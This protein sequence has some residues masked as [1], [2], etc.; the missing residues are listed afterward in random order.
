M[1]AMMQYQTR[2]R[3]EDA[4]R[5]LINVTD[6]FKARYMIDNK[7]EVKGDILP[8][9]IDAQM[10]IAF[11]LQKLD[12]QRQEHTTELAQSKQ[13]IDERVKDLTMQALKDLQS[14]M[15]DQFYSLLDEF[16]RIKKDNNQ[17][18]LE[19]RRL[20]AMNKDHELRLVEV[21]TWAK[22]DEIAHE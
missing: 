5:D 13:K 14:N 21:K 18:E 19:I 12:H 8:P 2:Q 11:L 3:V 10:K 22:W 7:I 15:K 20:E 4:K 17:K 16:E 9:L 1:I 6:T